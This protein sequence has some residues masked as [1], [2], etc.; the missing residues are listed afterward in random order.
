MF[1][2]EGGLLAMCLLA[3]TFSWRLVQHNSVVRRLRSQHQRLAELEEMKSTYLRLASHEL[4]TPIGVALGYVDLAQSGELGTL[5]QPAREALEQVS[6]SLRDADA[7]LTEM[8]EIAR[9]QEGRR[10]LKVDKLDLRETVREAYQRVAPLTTS[11]HVLV[12]QPESPLWI[13]GDR[14]RLRS[15]VRN[16][17]ENAIK[18]SPEGGEIR[19]SLN[20]AGGMASITVSDRGLGIPSSQVEKLF[21]R[22]ER[23]S[24]AAPGRIPGTGLGLHLAREIARAHG[25]DLTVSSHRD[26]GTTFVLSLP[27]SG[28]P[29][30]RNGRL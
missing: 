26:V 13:E 9:M 8:V 18:Y 5:P 17:L 3:M 20:D 22:F 6:A 7:L 4:R 30:V 2:T 29:D 10:L 27:L 25:G 19:C 24:Q 21:Q 16:L 15:A 1:S 14:L 11:H 12:S 28:G 23:A